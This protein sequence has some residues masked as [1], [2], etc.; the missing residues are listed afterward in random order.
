MRRLASTRLTLLGMAWLA[1]SAGLSYD[2]PAATSVWML[3][4]PML[5]LALNLLAAIITQPGINRRPGLLVFHIGLFGICVLAAV[6]RLTFF[7]AR[8]ELGQ[9]MPF[10]TEM[11]ADVRQGPWHR[12][13]L[14]QVNFT[15]GFYTVDYAPGLT[16]GSTRSQVLLPQ[17]N[18][19]VREQIVGDDKPLLLEGYRF[20]TSFN[21]GFAPVLTWTPETGEP[22]TGTLNMPSYPMF[23]YKQD[24][25]WT[26]PGSKPIKFWLRLDT[27]YTKEQSWV[28][29]GRKAKG[30]LV[31]NNGE[32]RVELAPGESVDLPGGKLRYEQL[33]T[34][35]GY[36]I[37]YD[38]TLYGLFISAITAVLGLAH[39]YWRKFASQP[40]LATPERREQALI[41]NRTVKA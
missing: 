15:Q 38:P 11:L 19:S 32:R 27:G 12:G 13:A 3:T 33:S 29:D 8:F 1:V 40:L 24:S 7:E 21:K 22:V 36:K 18:G 16:R 34:W 28:L 37:F 41:G 17:A 4:S 10:S 2:D 20:Y 35:I 9:G 39:H 6:G 14:E 30:V 26:P 23:E 31:V 25:E 5:F